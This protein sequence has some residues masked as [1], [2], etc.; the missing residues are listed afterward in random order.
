MLV[1]LDSSINLNRLA[2]AIEKAVAAHPSMFVRLA[3]RKGEPVQEF[4]AEDY[5]QTVEQMTEDAWQKKLSAL[6][7]APLELH[8]GR[9]FRFD[10][11]QTEKARYLL[12]TTHHVSFDRSAANVFF[13]DVAKIYNDPTFELA[14][15]NQPDP[16]DRIGHGNQRIEFFGRTQFVERLA[17]EKFFLVHNQNV[18]EAWK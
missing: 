14:P 18:N 17:T 2:D 12:R 3:E 7:A 6:V 10:L 4:V 5:H 16:S 15:G 8:G 1:T 11:V 9:L 13:D